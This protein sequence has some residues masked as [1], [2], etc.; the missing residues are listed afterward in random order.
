MCVCVGAEVVCM[1]M[2]F[3]IFFYYQEHLTLYTRQYPLYDQIEDPS[4][5]ISEIKIST[6]FVVYSHKRIGIS[7]AQSA[8][9]MR[10]EKNHQVFQ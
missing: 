3:C 7:H 2:L 4:P 5:L 10:I 6:F 1:W 8:E 9:K